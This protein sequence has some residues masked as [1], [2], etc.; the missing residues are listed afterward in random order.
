MSEPV[1]LALFKEH[2][3]LEAEETGEDVNLSGLIVG[4]RRACENHIGRTVDDPFLTDDDRVTIGR[5]I[6]LIG[7]ELYINRDAAAEMPKVAKWLLEPMRDL[8]R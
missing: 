1:S 2:L 5:A 3:R 4:A 7:G 6:L 8:S